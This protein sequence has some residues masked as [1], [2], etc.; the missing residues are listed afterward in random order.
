MSSLYGE[1]VTTG[2]SPGSTIAYRLKA[3]D[4]PKNPNKVWRGKVKHCGPTGVLV[5]M[6][7]PDYN[8]LTEV[9]TYEQVIAVE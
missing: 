8:G 1:D 4:L 9:V 6:L 7:E 3:S 2:I 5:E